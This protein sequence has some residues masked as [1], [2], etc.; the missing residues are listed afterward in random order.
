MVLAKT[1]WGADC[2]V[3]LQLYR[4]LIRSWLDYGSIVYSSA[5]LENHICKC[6]IVILFTIKD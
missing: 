1:K 6:Y 3:L 2:K 5:L 4:L